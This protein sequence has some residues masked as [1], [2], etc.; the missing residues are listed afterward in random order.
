MRT[1]GFDEQIPTIE[2]TAALSSPEAATQ[3]SRASPAAPVA[4]PAADAIDTSVRFQQNV[5]AFYAMAGVPQMAGGFV[6][7]QGTDGAVT[8]S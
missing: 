4:T 8:G 6:A 3:G 7:N 5:Q 1:G 2:A